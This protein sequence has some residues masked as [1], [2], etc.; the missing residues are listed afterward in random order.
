MPVVVTAP[1]GTSSEATA[2]DTADLASLEVFPPQAA[3]VVTASGALPV[4]V[5]RPPFPRPR[6]WEVIGQARVV[7]VVRARAMVEPVLEAVAQVRPVLTAKAR[8][9]R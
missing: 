2:P 4:V 6:F 7:R 1:V 8:L 9:T 5:L 3:V